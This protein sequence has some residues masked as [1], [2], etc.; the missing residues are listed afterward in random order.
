M[1]FQIK[2]KNNN[3]YENHWEQIPIANRP[4]F[5]HSICNNFIFKIILCILLLYLIC[6][7]FDMMAMHFRALFSHNEKNCPSFE[8]R[9][10]VN[11]FFCLFSSVVVKV[12]WSILFFSFIFSIVWFVFHASAFFALVYSATY[13][14][15]LLPKRNFVCHYI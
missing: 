13:R 15:I 2:K 4:T 6:K 3:K 9:K 8:F 11:I 10:F 5:N 7:Y 14:C 12:C 1:R